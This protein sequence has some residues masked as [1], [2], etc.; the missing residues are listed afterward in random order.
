ML[1]TLTRAF[2]GA[3]RR[4]LAPAA[5]NAVRTAMVSRAQ[6]TDKAEPMSRDVTRLTYHSRK[7]GILETTLI[8]SAFADTNLTRLS[9]ADMADYE[10]IIMSNAWTEW[11]L[12]RYLTAK[13]DRLDAPEELRAL[14][15]F[16]RIR[17]MVQQKG[18]VAKRQKESASQTTTS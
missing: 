10:H 7:R 9:A 12:Y 18:G 3:S 11:D 2:S 16:W 8:L 17:E 13:D 4:A 15:V 6:S 1:S 14:P 5:R